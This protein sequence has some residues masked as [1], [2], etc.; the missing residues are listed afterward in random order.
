MNAA[1]PLCHIILLLTTAVIT[2]GCGQSSWS[3]GIKTSNISNAATNN[4]IYAKIAYHVGDMENTTD[5]RLLN[6]TNC[7]DFEGGWDYFDQFNDISSRPWDVIYINHNDTHGLAITSIKY[8]W[9]DLTS[10]T[11]ST[12]NSSGAGSDCFE[13]DDFWVNKKYVIYIWSCRKNT[14]MMRLNPFFQRAIQNV[15]G[16]KY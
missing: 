5:Y 2:T 10:R 8:I 16:L 13:G 3:L 4:S 12:F 6:N 9:Q 11:Y 1:H 15:S 7:D 14:I